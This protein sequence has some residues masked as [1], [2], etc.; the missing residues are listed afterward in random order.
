MNFGQK[1]TLYLLLNIVL[2]GAAL[3]QVVDIPDPHLRAAIQDA[4]LLRPNDPIPVESMRR[5]TNLNIA[6]RNIQS[7]EG[8]QFAIRLESLDIADNHV[9]DFSPLSNLKELFHLIATKNG[10]TDLT[11]LGNLTQLRKLSLSDN[12]ITDIRPLANLVNLERLSLSWCRELIDISTLANLTKLRHL[13]L[14]H[15]KIRDITPLASLHNLEILHI[16][17]NYIVDHSPVDNLQLRE[18]IYDQECDMPDLS[19]VPRIENR[20]FPSIFGAFS[21][22]TLNQHHLSRTEQFAQHD[23]VFQAPFF[24]LEL[25]G[26]G[27][28]WEIRGDI[29]DSIA[30]RDTLLSLNPNLLFLV[31]L[32]FFNAGCNDYPES[33][34]YWK[35][36]EHGNIVRGGRWCGIDF[37]NPGFQDLLVSQAIAVSKCGL[38]DGIFLDWWNELGPPDELQARETIIRRIRANTRSDLLILVNTNDRLIPH[39]APF[40]N[41]AF[42][43]SFFPH[44]HT[45]EELE[46]R[47]TRGETV[48]SWAESNLKP[49]VINALAAGT[50]EAE[51]PDS[52]YNLRWM[53]VVTTL[54]LTHS[55]GYVYFHVGTHEPPHYWYD[56]WDADLGQPVGEKGQLYQGIDGLYIREFTNGWAVYNHSGEAQVITLPE[57]AQGVASGRRNTEHALPNLDGEIYLRVKPPNPADVNSDGVVNILDLVAV[58]QG[59]GTDNPEA[60]INGD[61]M[62][63]VFDLVMVANQF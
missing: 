43:E 30:R 17:H 4:L 36:D 42:I 8:L 47:V 40:I 55:D 18:F 34:P 7:L 60:D 37:T 19:S 56:F 22:T 35:R 62:V 31:E 25:F 23:M 14:S 24:E 11:T 13:S 59:L 15:N 1:I 41:G 38:Y 9:T 50:Y 21:G 58:A 51:P 52:P 54:S 16:S 12:P 46:K 2:G 10:I 49:P 57:E 39:T 5:I 26:N 45:G 63:N 44:S 6:K 61:G 20:Q 27:D 3:A 28:Y 32:R 53:R 48:L 33:W 29:N